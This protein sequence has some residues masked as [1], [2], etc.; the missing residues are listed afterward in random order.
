MKYILNKLAIALIVGGTLITSCE[1]EAKKPEESKEVAEDANDKKFKTDSSEDKAQFVVDA[2]AGNIA[3]IKLAQL[4]QEK[5]GSTELKGIAKMLEEEHT[6]ALGDLKS[7]ATTKGITIPTEES[8]KVKETIKDLSED[9][10][11][12]FDKAWTKELM[13]KHEK[14]IN[15]YE[16]E[17]GQSTDDAVKA[18][19][20]TVLPK[21]RSHH[22]KLMAYH[23]KI[24]K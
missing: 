2:V 23:S 14:T 9:K 24:T 6:A 7:L 15:D 16:K 13:D 8:D 11:S 4:A 12:D 21:I 20:N 10:P 5:S 18:W 3:E 19:I 22:D 17:L 1:G